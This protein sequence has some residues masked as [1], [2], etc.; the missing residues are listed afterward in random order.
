MNA[1]N[2]NDNLYVITDTVS[3][4]VVFRGSGT[5][6]PA[7]FPVGYC[8][9]AA[10]HNYT[11]YNGRYKVE[12]VTYTELTQLETTLDRNNIPMVEE[13]IPN[14]DILEQKLR[15]NYKYVAAIDRTRH[16]QCCGTIH[17]VA[18]ALHVPDAYIS[19]NIDSD[20]DIRGYMIVP[21]KYKEAKMY[22]RYCWLQ[23]NHVPTRVKTS[24]S[25]RFSKL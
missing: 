14:I 19:S 25:I 12:S 2:R 18:A 17:A 3:G 10:L 9:N 5:K 1:T 8:Y 21:A 24:S 6:L 20:V 13:N 4:E 22:Q 16:I 23:A 15:R 11:L 7:K